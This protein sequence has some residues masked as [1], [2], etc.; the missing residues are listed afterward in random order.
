MIKNPIK[1]QSEDVKLPCG[2]TKVEITE[3]QGLD[4][5]GGT[6]SEGTISITLSV[7]MGNDGKVCTWTVECQNNCSHKK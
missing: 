3:N 4:V 7:Y 6:F 1:R 5:T 2:D